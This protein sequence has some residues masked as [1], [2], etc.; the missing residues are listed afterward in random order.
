MKPGKRKKWFIILIAFA[1]LIVVGLFTIPKL[2]NPNEY[3]PL[4]EKKIEAAIGGKVRIG[5][6]TWGFADGIWL[7]A[8]GFSL[9]GASAF[10]GDVTLN[11]V[12]ANVS[13]LPL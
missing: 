12:H 7:E 9:V 10:P 3:T 2:L 13:I 5:H 11:R 1:L 8:D 6:V 4:I